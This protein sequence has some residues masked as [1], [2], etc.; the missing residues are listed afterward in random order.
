LDVYIQFADGS[1][2]RPDISIFR[3][4]PVLAES[5][6]Q[7]VPDVVVEVLSLGTGQKDLEVGPPFCLSLGVL[8]F[9]TSDPGSW[10]VVHFRRDSVR[11]YTSPVTLQL[12]CG[13]A[14]TC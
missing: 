7:V 10:C 4:K 13:C 11:R 6:L 1:L 12:E 2:K 9:V 3:E 8:D 14:I 5:A